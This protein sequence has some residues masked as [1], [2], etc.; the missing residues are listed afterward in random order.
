MRK[1]V[2]IAVVLLGI[3]PAALLAAE[4]AFREFI[5]VHGDQLRDGEQ[6]FRFI[7][8]NVPNLHCV[9]DNLAIGV[10]SPWRLPDRFE[11][12]DALV[13]VRIM[14]GNVV[15][16]YVISVVRT[17]DPPGT[18]RYVLGPGKF[19]E[20]AF[21]TLDEVLQL[22]N[23]TGVRLILP[24]VD[25]WSWWG[26]A[27]EYAGFHGKPKDAFW[28]DSEVIADFKNTI[29][30]VLT[31]TNTLTGIPY[32]EDK[33]ILCWETG[34]E[35]T[36]PPEWTRLIAA[37]IKSLDKHH[38]VM[39]GFNSTE[40]RPESLAMPE[41]DIVTTHHYPGGNKSYADLARANWEKAT[42]KKPYVIGEFGFQDTT[43][44]ARMLEAVEQ[45]GISGA[46]L[47]SLRPHNRDGGF[48]WHSEPAGGNKYK[49]Y[50]CPGFASGEEYD[51]I[52]LLNLMR[53]KAFE[54]RGLT[55]PR[56]PRP[57]PPKML[58]ITDGVG[59]SWQG[60]AGASSYIVERSA[61]EEGP[62]NPA[63]ED[64]DESA[65]QYRPLFID[66]K[67]KPGPWFYRARAR[68]EAG[69][70]SPSNVVGPVLVKYSQFVDEMV[71]L[72]LTYQKQGTLELTTQDS[73]KAREDAHR[74]RG[75]AGSSLS[76]KMAGP[77]RTWKVYAF[78]PAEISDF[79]FAV[80][81]DDMPETAVAT[82]KSIFFHGEGDYGYWKAVVYEGKADSGKANILKIDY[83]TQA[84]LGRVEIGYG[85]GE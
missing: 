70:S 85:G 54:I 83:T 48:Y 13:T 17:N 22:A 66:L 61:N 57:D 41:I 56:F 26:G 34:N 49:A 60:S 64:I 46:L 44:V 21:R 14:G 63:G 58:P 10:Q 69:V 33:A 81:A 68:N 31:R 50:H 9:E 29:R 84:Q 24:L 74:V 79:R 75:Q 2:V 42:G 37:Y 45:T 18:P 5:T 77:I 55:F 47:W 80:L 16:P 59:L 8:F 15:R 53:R 67:A 35:L 76:Y 72:S 38:L 7:S 71:D 62:W 12:L 1:F 25:C 73:R 40:L 39:D 11:I 19:N 20:E 82:Q 78:F 6:P 4:S 3:F 51:E 65:V 36:S 43:E 30:Y 32:H 52:H 28:T 27:A 23:Q